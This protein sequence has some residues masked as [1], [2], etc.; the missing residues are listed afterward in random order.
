MLELRLLADARM[1]FH[2]VVAAILEIDAALAADDEEVGVFLIFCKRLRRLAG[3]RGIGAGEAFVRRDDEDEALAVGVRLEERVREILSGVRRDFLHDF[4]D[5]FRVRR[6]GVR[7]FFGVAQA[8]RRDH[9]HGARDLL[10]ARHALDAMADV[11]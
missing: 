2:D 5:L 11:L 6:V 9:V 4:D 7:R 3:I 8:A 1:G 10:R